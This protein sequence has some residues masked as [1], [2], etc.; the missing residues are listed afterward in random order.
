MLLVCPG[1]DGVTPGPASPCRGLPVTLQ[2]HWSFAR[3][4]PAWASV[5]PSK[6]VGR[7]PGRVVDKPRCQ[8]HCMELS[9]LL[10]RPA[11]EPVSRPSLTSCTSLHHARRSSSPYACRKLRLVLPYCLH[12]NPGRWHLGRPGS[13]ADDLG[14]VPQDVNV[15][16]VNKQGIGEKTQPERQNKR[17]AAKTPQLMA[18]AIWTFAKDARELFCKIEYPSFWKLIQL[19]VVAVVFAVAF[20]AVVT[21]IDRAGYLLF[22]ARGPL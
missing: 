11:S 21:I 13:V 12:G 9:G 17:T 18:V 3:G 4:W 16:R 6:P 1:R 2:L 15:P 5:Y 8:L 19:T 14:A 7:I 10:R 22:V 20:S